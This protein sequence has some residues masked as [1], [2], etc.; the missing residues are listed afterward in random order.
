[1]KIGMIFECGKDGPDLKVCEVLA[2][3]LSDGIEI[4]SVTLGNKPGLL[5]NCGAAARNLLEEGC[6]RILIVWDLFPPWRERGQKPDR[7]RDRAQAL[8]SIEGAMNSGREVVH[9]ICIMAEL[10]TW[11]LADG[12]ALSTV[13]STDTRRVRVGDKKNPDRITNPK[14]HLMR[15]FKQHTGANYLDHYHAAKIANALPD[16]SRLIK[17]CSFVRFRER[18]L[19]LPRGA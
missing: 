8:Q 12:R 17:I 2:R 18:L 4:S 1:M 19:G 10:E 5:Q 13:L 3:M 7:E 16:L 11:L 14:Q 15:L 9:L 6:E